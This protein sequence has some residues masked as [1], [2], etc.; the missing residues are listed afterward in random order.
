MVPRH[1][2]TD[3]LLGGEDTDRLLGSEGADQHCSED[4]KA[5]GAKGEQG[6]VHH[7]SNYNII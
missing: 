2:D 3:R 6:A 1:E 5:F 4:V 7:Q